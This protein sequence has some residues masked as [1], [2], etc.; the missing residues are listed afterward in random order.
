MIKVLVVD[1]S[2]LV[3]GLLTDIL[4][5]DPQLKVV[6]AAR[7]PYEAREMIK[8]LNP[9]VLT[10]DIEMPKMN[11][12]AFLSNLMRLR[13]MPVVMISTLTH[14]G[15]PATLEALELGAVDFLPKPQDEGAMGQYQRV[16]VEKVKIAA[17]ANLTGR[18]SNWM[19]QAPVKPSA[20][21][22]LKA[23]FICAI[24]ASTG[25]TE[26]IKD[27]LRVLP[28]ESPPIMV[29]QHI[30][31]AFSTSFAQR[32]DDNCEIKV[33]EAKDDQPVRAG[34]A[35]LAPGDQ[36]LRL[37]RSSYG[38]VCK[39]TQGD[40]VNRHR[41]SVEVLFQS[42]AETAGNNAMAVMLTGM[43]ADGAQA[44]LELHQKGAMTVAQ[45]EATSVVWGMPKAAVQLGAAEKVLPL[46]K[47]A[48]T[49]IR[50]AYS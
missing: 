32:L 33:F 47:I 19:E 12:I 49:I 29:T 17:S 24:G 1:D 15:A 46:G 4:S 16:I 40:K 10:L 7:D 26:A 28:K 20:S 13:P 39:L 31:A 44:M 18:D 22:R 35:Y 34:C 27:V 3:R 2:A 41:P 37:E 38:Y 14:A 48:D 5:S 9:D 30:P 50:A 45:D 6:G 8:R 43:G 25:G 36:H 11:G 21:T 42:V 23:N